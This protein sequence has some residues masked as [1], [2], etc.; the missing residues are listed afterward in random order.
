MV[1]FNH[2]CNV[3][4]AR[5]AKAVAFTVRRVVVPGTMGG[6]ARLIA[7]KMG[8]GMGP[9]ELAWRGRKRERGRGCTSGLVPFG[10]GFGGAR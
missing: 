10:V 5:C 8:V 4:L 6:G 2:R 9:R 7:L 1:F 3:S